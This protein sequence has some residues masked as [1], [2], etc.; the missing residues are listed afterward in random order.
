MLVGFAAWVGLAVG[1]I[2]AADLTWVR[3]LGGAGGETAHAIAVDGA[4]STITTGVFTGTVDFDPGP[5][6][7]PLTASGP[8]AVYVS[9][10]DAD[11]DFVWARLFHGPTGPTVR[12]LA[13]DGSGNVYVV[14]QF[15]A[16]VD[17][18]PG[19][20]TFNLTSAG[21]GDAYLAK[22]DAAGAFVWALRWGGSSN[23]I[24]DAVT[25][26]PGRVHAGGNF[27]GTVDFDPGPGSASMTSAGS[28]DAFVSTFTDTGA[29]VWARRFG[30]TATDFTTRL[31]ADTDGDPVIY[32]NF[33]GLVDFD[34]GAAVFNLP[35]AGDFDVFVCKLTTGGT[36]AWARALGGFTTDIATALVVDDLDRVHIAGYFAGTADFDPG[37]GVAN[38]TSAG[39]ADAFVVQLDAN[40]NYAW[41][42]SAGGSGFDIALAV[43][44]LPGGGTVAGGRF[45]GTVDFDPGPAQDPRTAAGNQPDA[46]LSE[47]GA[48][49]GY[50]GVDIFT[51]GGYE[52][53]TD[54]VSDAAAR[55]HATG[56][57]SGSPDFDPG[58]GVSILASAGSTDAYVARLG[59]AGPAAP[60]IASVEIGSTA[61]RESGSTTTT[62]AFIVAVEGDASLLDV[63]LTPPSGPPVPLA[64][65]AAEGAFFF[66]AAGYPSL[67]ALRADFPLGAYR[68]DFNAATSSVQLGYPELEPACFAQ[69]AFPA[70]G[71]TVSPTPTFAWSLP[72]GCSAG[73]LDV[74]L[75]L[76]DD[77]EIFA[78]SFI[79][80][81]AG[82]FAYP[83]GPIVPAPV[84]P[85]PPL[86]PLTAGQSYRLGVDVVERSETSES[87]NGDVF[88]YAAS[89][90]NDLDTTFG[91]SAS[92]PV[93]DLALD[94]ISLTWSC[95]SAAATGFDVVRGDLQA[96]HTGGFPLATELCVADD[97]PV[98]SLPHTGTPDTGAGWWYLVRE[99]PP[100]GSYSSGGPAEVPGRDAG[101]AAS[102]ADCP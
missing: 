18:D 101:I 73:A 4:S 23:D 86:L 9:K 41:A 60:D 55:L 96:L 65:D 14:G 64:F 62:Y 17:F 43:A 75:D 47:Y 31:D 16:T 52:D 89:F 40:G 95:A 50:V 35:A 24:A 19:P 54:L 46:F 93:L 25:V 3:G 58:P 30:S 102:G 13:V 84:D 51:G 87:V 92:G 59:P 8:S 82:S 27:V 56:T 36:L 63:T 69:V 32:G 34:P 11:G 1:G 77:T 39:S 57:F 48:T 99:A 26:T 2:Q 53:V 85:P 83:G 88:T 94:P 49:G 67:G 29:F 22:L 78:L 72:P 15:S 66:E 5:G 70:P 79:P 76:T 42:T 12:D 33:Q 91:V 38:R 44:V 37:A 97:H 80:A 61:A 81:A 6:V 68:L 71:C 90:R 20:A 74:G 28:T 45:E 10:L 21:L 98:P 100:G 7:A